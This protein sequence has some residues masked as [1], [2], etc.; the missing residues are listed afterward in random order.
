MKK[1]NTMIALLSLLMAIACLLAGCSAAPTDASTAALSTPP[2]SLSSTGMAA[3]TGSLI[4]K[5]NPEIL[6]A[7]D[8]DG[9]VT[10]LRGLN[11]DGDTVLAGYADY[12]GRD[13]R[14]VVQ[15]LVTRIH[16]QGYFVSE[17][18]GERRSITLEIEPDSFLPNDHFLDDIAGDVQNTLQALQLAADLQTNTPAASQ[19]QP[20]ASTG[21]HAGYNAGSYGT[22]SSQLIPTPSNPNQVTLPYPGSTDYGMTNYDDYGTT[23]Y[24]NSGYGSTNYDDYGTTNYGN[25]GYGST[26][27]DDYGTTNYGN[28]GYG[29]TNY[30]D[31]GSTN[32]GNSGYGSTNYGNSGYGNSWYGN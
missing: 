27:Y 29:S 17:I 22:P 18:D 28:S 10:E 14:T 23:N 4:L 20:S 8:R 11:A 26:N 7:Y 9:R 19:S 1:K 6:V 15:E 13:C 32:Y 24:G 16:D 2:T 30:D 3:E 21:G 5:V 25:S 12:L 31:Y